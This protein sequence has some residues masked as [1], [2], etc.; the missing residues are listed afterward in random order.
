MGDHK[1]ICTAIPLV[2]AHLARKYFFVKWEHMMEA[3]GQAANSSKQPFQ[4]DR[5]RGNIGTKLSRRAHVKSCC[6]CSM[7][8]CH[9]SLTF[10]GS[11][12]LIHIP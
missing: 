12:N 6:L 2:A 11:N 4:C 5:K 8:T 3:E 1:V 7:N 9:S 10:E